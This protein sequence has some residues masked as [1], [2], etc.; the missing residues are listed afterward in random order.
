[1]SDHIYFA[2]TLS[3]IDYRVD[4]GMLFVLFSLLD[5]AQVSFLGGPEMPLQTFNQIKIFLMYYLCTLRWA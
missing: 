2:A 4:S 1:M 3:E 5:G